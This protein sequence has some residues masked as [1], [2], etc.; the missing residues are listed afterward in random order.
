MKRL[1]LNMILLGLSVVLSAVFPLSVTGIVKEKSVPN[2]YGTEIKFTH[3]SWQEVLK[4]AS[5]QNKY[6]FVDAY[7]S[8]CGPCKQLK[9]TTFKN[10]KAAAF[11]NKNFVNVAIDM[12]KGQG[13]ELS[14]EWGTE[15]FPTL[16]VINPKGKIVSIIEGFVEPDELIRF[17]QQA[18]KK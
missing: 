9:A 13:R 2:R 15:S 5:A 3:K 12:E 8:W 4:Q 1:R 11:F 7:A 17:G 16:L 10:G 6:I 18:L 14:S